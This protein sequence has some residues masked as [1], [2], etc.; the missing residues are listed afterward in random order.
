MKMFKKL[1]AIALAGVMALAILTGCANYKNMVQMMNDASERYRYG[2]TVKEDYELTKKAK[3]LA[4]KIEAE[5]K[6]L[7]EEKTK[8]ISKEVLGDKYDENY[9]MAYSKPVSA[10]NSF[11]KDF[12]TLQNAELLVS[13]LNSQIPDG[14]T[15]NKIGITVIHDA[16]SDADY[17]F[18][19][20]QLE[21]KAK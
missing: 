5:G 17:L 1:M 6:D 21:D 2:L 12:Y 11:A 13:R 4:E 9:I 7:T 8:A 10:K 14:K 16:Q 18:V 20:A 3:T 19:L 15:V